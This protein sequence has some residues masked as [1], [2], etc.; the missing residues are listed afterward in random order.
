MVVFHHIP[1]VGNKLLLFESASLTKVDEW[2]WLYSTFFMPAFFVITGYCSNFNGDFNTFVR[3]NIKTLLFA[4]ITLSIIE[5][6]VNSTL[7]FSLVYSISLKKLVKT[8]LIHGTHYWFLTALFLDKIIFFVMCRMQLNNWI[9]GGVCAA[10]MFLAIEIYPQ[11]AENDSNNYW[12]YCH[13]LFFLIFVWVGDFMSNYSILEGK[14]VR[15]GLLYLPLVV[16]FCVINHYPP[17]VTHHLGL[18]SFRDIPLCLLLA[19]LGTLLVVQLAKWMMLYLPKFINIEYVGKVSLIIYTLHIAVLKNVEH[20]LSGHL[21]SPYESDETFLFILL[22]FFI[23]ILI[24]LVVSRLL[25]TSYTEW[26]I[27]KW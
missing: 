8:F 10:S 12:F 23:S 2:N 24:L 20:R 25:R 4:G 6:F 26:I 7:N 15:L 18:D 11:I 3:K 16:F 9:K 14:N 27:G 13:T 21:L 17:M 19:I 1:Q 5:G 22:T